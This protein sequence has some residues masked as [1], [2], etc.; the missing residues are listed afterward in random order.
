MKYL[1]TAIRVR[2]LD[3]ALACYVDQLGFEVLHRFEGHRRPCTIVFV[4]QPGDGGAQIELVWYH[5]PAERERL[6]GFSHLGYEVDD[7]YAECQALL[8][9]GATLELPPSDGFMA[10]VR[11]PDGV[12]FELLQ[13]GGRRPPREPWASMPDTGNW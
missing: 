1:H 13:K 4:A 5:D 8:D 11:G 10:F 12:Q 9:R 2:D 3:A 6:A 7:I